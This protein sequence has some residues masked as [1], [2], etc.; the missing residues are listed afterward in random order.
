MIDLPI[1]RG[2]EG[3]NRV[4]TCQFL[5]MRPLWL[6][7]DGSEKLTD[8]QVKCVLTP[9]DIPFEKLRPDKQDLLFVDNN[10]EMIPYWIEKADSTEIIV[11]LKFSAI[12]PGKEVFWLYYG[13]GNFSGASDGDAVFEFFDDFEDGVID[14]NKW[15]VAGTTENVVEEGGLLKITH[16]GGAD[17]VVYGKIDFSYGYSM[18][19]RVRYLQTNKDVEHGWSACTGAGT[20]L[21]NCGGVNG[22]IYFPYRDG[23]VYL[24]TKKDGETTTTQVLPSYDTDFHVWELVRNSASKVSLYKDDEYVGANTTNIPVIDLHPAFDTASADYGGNS[25]I[26]WI[27]VRK[28]ADPEPFMRV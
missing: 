1:R 12:I 6:N 13:N 9:S 24:R 15:G 5:R 10:N 27:L 21:C 18:R 20:Y 22:A 4:S 11:W 7:Y 14:T 16:A 23:T 28:Y 19:L 3:S 8:F 2:Y 17:P 25:E 26:D